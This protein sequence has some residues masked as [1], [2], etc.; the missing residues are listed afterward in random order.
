MFSASFSNNC[1]GKGFGLFI[2][3]SG[4]VVLW[5]KRHGA[6]ALELE[7]DTLLEIAVIVT[8]GDTLEEVSKC[9]IYM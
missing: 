9:R 3:F 4:P 1:H 6:Y 5:G 8:E 2:A 7:T